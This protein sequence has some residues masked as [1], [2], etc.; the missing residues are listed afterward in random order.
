MNNKLTT[1]SIA[2]SFILTSGAIQAAEPVHISGGNVHFE[3]ELVHGACAL[4]TRSGTQT[5]QLGFYRTS[6]F[7]KIGDT[8]PSVPF[9]LIVNECDQ[10][11]ASTASVAFSGR[12]DARDSSLLS[13][14]SVN[15]GASAT[16]VGIE[17][18]DATSKPLKPDGATFSNTQPLVGG[19]NTLR[20]SA[21]YKATAATATAGQANADATFIMK[22]E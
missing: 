11:I 3:G 15:N 9:S 8:T 19:T 7:T 5:V 2:A 4:S 6:T 16:G 14:S 18:L 20:F 17:I 10:S 13:L 12:A 21:R 22:Y 1:L